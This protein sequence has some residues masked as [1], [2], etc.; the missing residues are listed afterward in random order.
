MKKTR[1]DIHT[2]NKCTVHTHTYDEY[3]Y[4]YSPPISLFSHPPTEASAYP[5]R[6]VTSLRLSQRF[7]Q[8]HLAMLFEITAAKKCNIKVKLNDKKYIKLK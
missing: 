1:A 2:T 5:P 8:R 4:M 6:M 7:R 3:T